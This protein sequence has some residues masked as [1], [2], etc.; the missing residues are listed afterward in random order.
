M[1]RGASGN[2]LGIFFVFTAF[3]CILLYIR[4]NKTAQEPWKPNGSLMEAYKKQDQSQFLQIL[5]RIIRAIL[6]RKYVCIFP[7]EVIHH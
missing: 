4:F 6:D 1:E 2:T 5:D 3:W 7:Q